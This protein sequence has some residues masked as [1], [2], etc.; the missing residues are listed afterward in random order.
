MLPK[1]FARRRLHFVGV[2]PI[3]L[4][5]G[6]ASPGTVAGIRRRFIRTVAESR[7]M[8]RRLLKERDFEVRNSMPRTCTV[9][10]HARRTQID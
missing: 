3:S 6:D 9:C 7:D 5:K 10:T 2:S 4:T 1:Q 8:P